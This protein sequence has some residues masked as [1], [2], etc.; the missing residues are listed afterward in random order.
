MAPSLTYPADAVPEVDPRPASLEVVYRQHFR[1]TWR[2]LRRLGVADAQLDDAA[3][4]VFLVVH[5]RLGE[6]A[7]HSPLRSWLFAIAV[8]VA[9][10]YRRRGAR[11]RAESLDETI[12]DS[13]TYS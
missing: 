8:R 2:L 1:A 13:C 4:D 6:F 9:S 10:D 7:P 11:A 12:P 5:R 3:Q